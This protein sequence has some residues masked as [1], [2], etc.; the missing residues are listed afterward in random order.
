MPFL[1]IHFISAPWVTQFNIPALSLIHPSLYPRVFNVSYTSLPPIEPHPTSPIQ[2][3]PYITFILYS[4]YCWLHPVYVHDISTPLPVKKQK[5]A[6]PTRF[7]WNIPKYS[8]EFIPAWYYIP[9]RIWFL[10]PLYF[11]YISII[12]PL[13][14][15]EFIYS[16]DIPTR[17]SWFSPCI[18]I[19][20]WLIPPPPHPQALFQ[21]G[22]LTF[23]AAKR[24]KQRDRILQALVWEDLL[25]ISI[26][27]GAP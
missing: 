21:D 15:H 24:R 23:T 8:H 10:F 16:H 13:Y 12:L 14:S 25:R 19:K 11:H 3:I 20:K 26:Q 18:S 5:N 22:E 6:I 4:N 17:F 7:L 9:T 27:G 2:P 1:N